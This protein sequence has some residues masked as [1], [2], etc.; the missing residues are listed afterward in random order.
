MVEALADA[1]RADEGDLGGNAGH[2]ADVTVLVEGQVAREPQPFRRRQPVPDRHS[3]GHVPVDVPA[4]QRLA[5]TGLVHQGLHAGGHRTKPFDTGAEAVLEVEAA[6]LPVGDHAEAGAFLERH[7]FPDA[8]IL[9]RAQVLGRHLAGV[10]TLPDLLEPLRTQQAADHV[11]PHGCHVAH[12]FLLPSSLEPVRCPG[13]RRSS[14][15]TPL[16]GPRGLDLHVT[17][18]V[19]CQAPEGLAQREP[20]NGTGPPLT[21]REEI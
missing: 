9:H 4:L 11:G 7:R 3:G 21:R 10:E 8:L 14:D 2:R 15:R 12:A 20:R 16:P 19:I 18:H 5:L 1:V 17:G 6:E 13:I